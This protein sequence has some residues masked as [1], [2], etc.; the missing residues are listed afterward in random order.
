M[1]FIYIL[2][3]IVTTNLNFLSYVVWYWLIILAPMGTS[4][5][6][7]IYYPVFK[8]IIEFKQ[9]LEI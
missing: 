7:F 2:K 5:S 6:Y 4:N 3:K 9:N 1:T 8:F